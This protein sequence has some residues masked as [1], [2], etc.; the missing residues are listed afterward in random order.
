MGDWNDGVAE[1]KNHG[2]YDVADL[3]CDMGQEWVALY[4]VKSRNKGN[5]VLADSLTVQYG[6]K[7]VYFFWAADE[8]AFAKE[9]A[10]TFGTGQMALAGIGGLLLGI[11]GAT[12][13]LNKKRKKD[14]LEA[15]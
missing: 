10:S 12:L 7:G 13:V 1:Y 15:A 9:T 3:N 6:K 14:E 2:C 8:K 11:A 4:T 5:P